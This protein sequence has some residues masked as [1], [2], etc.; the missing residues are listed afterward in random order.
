M[1][2]M[3]L[4]VAMTGPF[5]LVAIF[6]M[7]VMVFLMLR[8]FVMSFIGV[9]LPFWR[10]VGAVI[11]PLMPVFRA[12]KLDRDGGCAFRQT[13]GE[14]RESRQCDQAGD[15]SRRHCEC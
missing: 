8:I 9:A 3:A 6:I 7:L 2:V 11:M 14:A 12:K 13:R 10:F 1:L 15:C 5:S 4:I